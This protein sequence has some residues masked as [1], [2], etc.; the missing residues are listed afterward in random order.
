M[1][2]ETKTSAFFNV[3]PGA[4]ITFNS[5]ISEGSELMKFRPA[6]RI[7]SI[8]L[9]ASSVFVLSSFS[10]AYAQSTPTPTTVQG[11]APGTDLQA[12]TLASQAITALVGQS[13]IRDVTLT[14]TVT[15]SVG[16][17]DAGNATLMALGSNE[18]RVD[19]ELSK[20]TR[21]EIRDVSTGTPG[22]KWINPDGGSGSI[23]FHNTLTDAVWFFPAFGSLSPN[24]NTVLSFVGAETWKGVAVEHLRSYSLPPG[25]ALTPTLQ[26]LSTMD[27]YVAAA[28]MLPVS[29]TLN[30][31][32]DNNALADIPTEV[33]FSNYQTINGIAVPMHIQ[34][35]QNGHLLDDITV[36][37]AVFN[38][39][40]QLSAF[41]SN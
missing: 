17:T 5:E 37:S 8:C 34:R 2:T 33:D 13:V 20:G 1:Q 23:A 12:A 18:S 35:F 21:T 38:S 27:F 25:Q 6:N 32:A 28:T 19:F 26:Q 10:V 36:S 15:R 31:H 24:P 11:F 41:A 29:V 16:A 3:A 9:F 39:G 40:L 4:N 14:G 30:A 7:F 22:G